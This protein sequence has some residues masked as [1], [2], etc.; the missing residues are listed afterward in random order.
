ME[1]V[2][3]GRRF[4]GLCIVA[5]RQHTAEG[6]APL[7]TGVVEV[8][9][10]LYY[11]QRHVRSKQNV[12]PNI[13]VVMVYMTINSNSFIES[14]RAGKQAAHELDSVRGRKASAGAESARHSA[15]QL[16]V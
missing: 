6:T 1:R 11:K 14:P 15:R 5:Y 8:H 9:I 3:P 13:P 10:V 4:K 2:E 16:L 12:R 7:T